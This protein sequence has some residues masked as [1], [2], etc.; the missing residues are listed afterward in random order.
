MGAESDFLKVQI[1]CIGDD[2]ALSDAKETRVCQLPSLR[3]WKR[4]HFSS[5][6]MQMHVKRERK[7]QT[8]HQT[9]IIPRAQN[10]SQFAG[11]QAGRQASEMRSCGV[12]K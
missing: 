6:Q 12:L 2:A 9:R 10:V 8:W 3:I 11:R 7:S 5:A 1:F 4:T